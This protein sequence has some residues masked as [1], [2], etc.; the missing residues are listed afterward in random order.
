MGPFD[1]FR[2]VMSGPSAPQGVVEI[3]ELLERQVRQA[4]A[5]RG[6]SNAEIYCGGGVVT[7]LLAERDAWEAV[8]VGP[9]AYRFYPGFFSADGKSITWPNV[10]V[11][12]D[13]DLDK[14]AT[15]L[16]EAFEQA[17]RSGT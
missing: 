10:W 12:D 9:N 11:A 14:F 3:A 15:V 1:H 8:V 17:A 16:E 2:L 4:C 6:F 5:E 7:L 13:Y